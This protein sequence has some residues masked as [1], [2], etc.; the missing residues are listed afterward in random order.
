M[1]RTRVLIRS[2][3]AKNATEAVQAQVSYAEG[4]CRSTAHSQ[5]IDAQ[6][7]LRV[8]K[9]TIIRLSAAQRPGPVAGSV[10]QQKVDKL[11]LK[12]EETKAKVSH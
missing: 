1:A 12:Y 5:L 9:D 6:S 4:S 11:V 3:R 10:M 2:E 8:Q 7:E